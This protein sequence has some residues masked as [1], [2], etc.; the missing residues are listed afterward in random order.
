MDSNFTRQ[1]SQNS[2]LS[3]IFLI[4][5]PQWGLFKIKNFDP[6]FCLRDIDGLSAAKDMAETHPKTGTET[7]ARPIATGAITAAQAAFWAPRDVVPTSGR[8]ALASPA[9]LA[10]RGAIGSAPR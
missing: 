9:L 2:A 3:G 5:C 6:S 4:A 7:A 8:G 1:R 10:T